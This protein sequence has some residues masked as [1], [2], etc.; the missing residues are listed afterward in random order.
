MTI[1][2]VSRT[3]DSCHK[4]WITFDLSCDRSPRNRFKR[5]LNPYTASYCFSC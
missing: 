1:A 5:G 2:L 4:V 3:V